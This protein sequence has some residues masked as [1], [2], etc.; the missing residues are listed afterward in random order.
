MEEIWKSKVGFKNYQISNYGRI[1]YFKN[2]TD[3]FG[4]IIPHIDRIRKLTNDK[5]GYLKIRIM[6]DDLKQKDFQ[7]HTLVA[8]LFCDNPNNYKIVNHKD[9]DKKN[10]NY[11][12]LEWGTQKMNVEHSI[13]NGLT[14]PINW[15]NRWANRGVNK[16]D[17]NG[18]T[19]E[20]F[21]SIRSAARSIKVNPCKIRNC[22][23]GKSRTSG[24]FKWVFS[25]E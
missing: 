13:K 8:E 11:E 9:G 7:V 16:L 15:D 21:T 19:L 20:K 22:C 14:K 5:Y 23:A 17:D 6:S 2:K 1:K 12:N 4:N 25:N 24:G 10:N 18:D 3:S